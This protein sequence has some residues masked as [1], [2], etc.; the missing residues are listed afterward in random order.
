MSVPLSLE[1]QDLKALTLRQDSELVPTC[2]AMSRKHR[3]SLPS[4]SQANMRYSNTAH[5]GRRKILPIGGNAT[6]YQHL[7]ASPFAPSAGDWRL[8]PKHGPSLTSDA[9]AWPA[10]RKRA[11]AAPQLVWHMRDCRTPLD[12]GRQSRWGNIGVIA[13]SGDCACGGACG[14]LSRYL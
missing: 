8:V 6:C 1:S 3:T 12:R 5:G 4:F 2:R 14:V 7:G 11:C 10:P 13:A 9:C